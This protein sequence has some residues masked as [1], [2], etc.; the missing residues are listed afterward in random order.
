MST[1]KILSVRQLTVRYGAVIAVNEFSL[2]VEPGQVVGLIGPNGAGKT[3]LIDAITGFTRSTGSIRLAGREINDLPAHKRAQQGMSRAWQSLELFDDLTVAENLQASIVTTRGRGG[4]AR[5][6]ADLEEILQR[7]GL[8]VSTDLLP[9]ELSQGQ[10]KLLAL[11]RAMATSPHV[12]LAD[13][14]AAGLDTAESSLLGERLRAIADTG[15]GVLLIDHDMGLVLNLCDYIYAIDFGNPL[16]DGTPAQIRQDP[17][18]ISA[19]LG[20]SHQGTSAL[21]ETP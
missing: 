20:A 7:V 10:R 18:L 16:A 14:P 13:E 21:S 2:D 12:L 5:K 17:K 6:G 11:A 19:Y 9:T 15:V 4:R 8:D 3:S 1:E